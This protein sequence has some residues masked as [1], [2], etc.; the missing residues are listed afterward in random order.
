MH[1]G[2]MQQVKTHNEKG[3]EVNA[4]CEVMEGVTM[5]IQQD[6]KKSSEMHDEDDDDEQ[7]SEDLKNINGMRYK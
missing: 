1:G 5:I 3:N 6:I 2:G 7:N 4:G